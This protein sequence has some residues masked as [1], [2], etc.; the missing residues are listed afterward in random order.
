[1]SKLL[2]AV[3]LAPAAMFAFAQGASQGSGEV[4][5]IDKAGGRVEIRHGGIKALDM[6]PMRMNFRAR[7]A[8]MLDGLAVGDK[9]RFTAEKIDGQ[10]TVTSIGKAP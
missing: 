5:K 6:P 7:D 3:L 10:F 2:G 9:V 8:K 4:T 1:M